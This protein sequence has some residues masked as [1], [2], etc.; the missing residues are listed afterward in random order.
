MATQTIQT[1]ETTPASLREDDGLF[2]RMKEGIAGFFRSMKWALERSAEYGE[3][4]R[5]WP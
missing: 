1:P 5:Y 4:G 3:Y 2:R